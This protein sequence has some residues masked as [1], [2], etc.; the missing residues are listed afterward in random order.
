MELSRFR[1]IIETLERESLEKSQSELQLKAKPKAKPKPKQ[2][3]HILES[4]GESGSDQGSEKGSERGFWSTVFGQAG[5]EISQDE[6]ERIAEI[7]SS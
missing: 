6:E 5:L 3:S 2:R 7:Q 4:A 1:T